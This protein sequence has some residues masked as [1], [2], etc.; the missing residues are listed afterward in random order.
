M[1]K[2]T[3]PIETII[4]AL[5]RSEMKEIQA[6][7]DR[8]GDIISATGL[9][10]PQVDDSDDEAER[11]ELEVES[12]MARIIADEFCSGLLKEV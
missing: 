10:K 12:I 4:N 3:P 9:I 1:T 6:M 11:F 7:F 2:N 8:F 5:G